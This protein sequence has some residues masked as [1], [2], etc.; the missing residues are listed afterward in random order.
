[1]AAAMA[2]VDDVRAHY[3]VI[4]PARLYIT[5]MSMG[6]YGTWDAAVRHPTKWKAA[7]IVC[8]GYD[9]LV[10]A[11]IVRLPIWAFHAVDDPTVPV[12]RSRDIIAALKALGGSP[13]YTEYP[14]SAHHGHASWRPAYADP[15][16][17][18]WMFGPA[19]AGPPSK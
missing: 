7:V 18:P 19:A 13:R 17:L 11:P 1:M 15:E 8:G 10:V 3:P 16:L 6:G 9:E 5:G 4:D 14:A 12:A 2:L